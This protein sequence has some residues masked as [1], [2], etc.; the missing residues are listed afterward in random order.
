MDEFIP[1]H[2]PTDWSDIKEVPSVMDLPVTYVKW[3]IDLA[4]T[5]NYIQSTTPLPPTPDI[6]ELPS[7]VG[8]EYEFLTNVA[9]QVFWKKI[10]EFPNGLPVSGGDKLI[11]EQLG[12]N[13]K[14]SI[15]D[16]VALIPTNGGGSG[17]SSTA[18]E[19][20]IPSGIQNETNLEFTTLFSFNLTTTKLYLN[21]QRLKLGAGNDYTEVAPNKI[22]FIQSPH[23]SD[24]ILVD[25]NTGVD[26]STVKENETPGGIQNNINLIF[27]TSSSFVVNSTHLYLNG[28]RLKK[29]VGN[30]YT[31]S[32]VNQISFTEAP[33]L[34]D[35]L[36]ID[37]KY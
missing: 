31:E 11:V 18:R 34:T 29:G 1:I 7:N 33:Y 24:K 12:Q 5:L 32:G 25:Y 3:I 14:I 6:L 22:V 30:D 15:S 16:I 4:K 28:Q 10:S 20:E 17:G 9:S 26:T 13:R 2:I 8:H 23:L 27:T 35:K 36:I 21:G 19:N 37:Y